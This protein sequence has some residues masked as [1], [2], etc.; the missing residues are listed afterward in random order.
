MPMGRGFDLWELVSLWRQVRK[1]WPVFRRE[2]RERAQA[3]NDSR[4]GGA[5]AGGMRDPPA[6]RPEN[7]SDDT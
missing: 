7:K 2:L 5:T 4:G 3:A 1:I 6:A